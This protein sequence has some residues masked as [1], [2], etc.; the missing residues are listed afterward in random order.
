M[1]N[2]YGADYIDYFVNL[3]EFPATVDNLCSLATR[4]HMVINKEYLQ[5]KL[6][7]YKIDSLTEQELY[8]VAE[9]VVAGDDLLRFR[10]VLMQIENTDALLKTIEIFSPR[11]YVPGVREFL[12]KK[13]LPLSWD[14]VAQLES[15]IET[16]FY[17]EEITT[18][19][20]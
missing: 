19:K 20:K 11:V 1:Q 8:E 5:T 6:K 2:Y 9:I 12:S 16:K 15:V 14:D 3:I 17:N 13:S 10:N 18:Y 4:E 7:N